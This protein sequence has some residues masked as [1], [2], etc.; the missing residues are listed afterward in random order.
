MNLIEEPKVPYI[1]YTTGQP[2]VKYRVNPMLRNSDNVFAVR[3]DG[4]DR[5]IFFNPND[6]RALRMAKAIK[7]LDAEQLGWVL[8]NTAKVTRWIASVNTQYNPVFGA[9]NVLS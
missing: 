6:P 9:Y 4:K 2:Q 8:G 7:N 3:I 1:D 5:F